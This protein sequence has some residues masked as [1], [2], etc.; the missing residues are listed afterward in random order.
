M[1]GE[2]E[3]T[4]D[5]VI[6]TLVLEHL[7]LDVFFKT[8]R[9]FMREEGGVL[10]LTGMHAEMGRRSRAGFVDVD[11]SGGER[12]V[13]GSSFVY[14]V[15]EVLVE[16][17]KWG[18]AVDGE[19]GERAVCEEDVGEDLEGSALLGKRG[20]KWVGC[21]VWFGCVMRFEGRG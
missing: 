18:F 9:G 11:K 19:V 17:K 15:E 10:V 13:Q 7:P 16:G 8:V 21:K 12:K 2:I 5:L 4:A 6:S 14:E 1:L 20:R 3:G